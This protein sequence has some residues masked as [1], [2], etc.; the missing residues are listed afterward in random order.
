MKLEIG[1]IMQSHVLLIALMAS[2]NI[3]IFYRIFRGRASLYAQEAGQAV[4]K[5]V[6]GK[7]VSNLFGLS[8]K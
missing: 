8:H 2:K 4:A 6:L 1:N 7:F 3:L 5:S